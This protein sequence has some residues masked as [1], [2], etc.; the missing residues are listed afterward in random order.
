MV[1]TQKVYKE[2]LDNNLIP[3]FSANY[4]DGGYV[5]SPDLASSHYAHS[6]VDY[7]KSEKIELVP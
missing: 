5:F 3:L 7:V 1:I 4:P 2:A 6:V